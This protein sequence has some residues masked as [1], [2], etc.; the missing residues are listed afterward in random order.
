MHL[1]VVMPSAPEGI[2]VPVQPQSTPGHLKENIKYS[3]GVPP[4][5]IRIAFKD[6]LLDDIKTFDGQGVT[7][8]STVV[9]T[10]DESAPPPKP[11]E[12]SAVSKPTVIKKE[13]PKPKKPR[14]EVV[15]PE[16]KD[17]D[18]KKQKVLSDTGAK[19]TPSGKPQLAFLHVEQKGEEPED[20]VIQIDDKQVSPAWTEVAKQLS[21]G[22]KAIFDI[23]EKVLDFDPEGLGTS[24]PGP[25]T[26]ELVKLAD[27]EDVGNGLLLVAKPGK[28]T[29]PEMLDTC[30]VHWRMRRWSGICIASSRER[31]AILPGH[32]I[33][34]IEDPNA[35]AVGLSLGEGQQEAIET[36]AAK[37]KPGGVG[38]LYLKSEQVKANRPAGPVVVDVE[39]VD[40]NSGRPGTA[41]WKGWISLCNEQ[42]SG[43]EW[44]ERAERQ[45][46]QVETFDQ[47]RKAQSDEEKKAV[48]NILGQMSK[49]AL[50]AQRRYRR[51]D[52]WLKAAADSDTPDKKRAEL[53]RWRAKLNLAKALLVQHQ[54]FGD[55]ALKLSDEAKD[56]YKEA[57]VVLQCV[58]KSGQEEL[59][60]EAKRGLLQLYTLTQRVPEARKVLEELLKAQPDS[61]E[62]KDCSARLHRLETQLQLQ[63]GGS[64][65]EKVQ[66]D[67]RAAN[68]AKDM[69][70]VAAALDAL[71]EIF[72]NDGVKYDK[73]RDL[74]VGKDVGNAM[75]LGD[76]DV[77]AK[78][79]QIVGGIQRLA[80]KQ[81]AGL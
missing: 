49:W 30:M 40:V 81:D 53:E 47:M 55:D 51:F 13:E 3:M 72:A 7:D 50:N 58:L 77:A 23:K 67:L 66:Q 57:D 22:E 54:R 43:D 10:I 6:E 73:L 14:K 68:E 32:G 35:P 12:Q 45:R 39:M 28:G 75:K 62:L 76:P 20:L 61:I 69:A 21:V 33:V 5:H 2:N 17:G 4:K 78:A 38:H 11:E 59:E 46:E 34:Q 71:G 26:V 31:M 1:R 64:E 37:L 9:A 60:T 63:Q 19:W 80:Q 24:G 29:A 41:S 56:A 36:I 52:A 44:L 8:G 25:F 74:K 27:V 18:V 15:R 79:R 70:A 48:E 16:L 65:V 42:R